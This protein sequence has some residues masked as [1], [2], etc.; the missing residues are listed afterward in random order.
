MR[1]L[2]K[3]LDN[4]HAI[5]HNTT[6]S[7]WTRPCSHLWNVTP[8]GSFMGGS[9]LPDWPSLFCFP[10]GQQREIIVSKSDTK[11]LITDFNPSKDYIVSVSTVSGTA[12]SRP[13][14]GRYKG[15][16]VSSYL[17]FI[18][19]DFSIIISTSIYRIQVLSLLAP[20]PRT[21]SL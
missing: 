3:A 19:I 6:S 11:V 12:Q 5:P 2:W 18:C 21:N 17:W 13:L 8:N 7:P 4:V 10:G 9:D 14:Q 15:M 1:E 20:Q 16:H